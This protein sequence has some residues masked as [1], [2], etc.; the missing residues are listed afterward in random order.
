MTCFKTN[1]DE[2]KLEQSEHAFIK[3]ITRASEYHKIVTQNNNKGE[4]I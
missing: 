4:E 3:G 2:E 1:I